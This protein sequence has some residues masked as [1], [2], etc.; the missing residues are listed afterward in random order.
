[1]AAAR[2]DPGC[3]PV[4]EVAVR[5]LIAAL[6]AGM[7]SAFWLH[8]HAGFRL[9]EGAVMLGRPEGTVKADLSQ[10]RARLLGAVGQARA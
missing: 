8:H 1:M 5:S 3:Q 4:Q 6:P 7:R 2:P 10:A 9:H